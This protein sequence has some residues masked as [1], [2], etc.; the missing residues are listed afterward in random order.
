[1]SI[2][3]W[4]L[5]ELSNLVDWG[6]VSPLTWV[7]W[8]GLVVIQDVTTM[9][10]VYMKE[11]FNNTPA[12]SSLSTEER[13]RFPFQQGILFRRQGHAVRC[14]MSKVSR[15]SIMTLGRWDCSSGEHHGSATSL[16]QDGY[17]SSTHPLLQSSFQSHWYAGNLPSYFRKVSSIDRH[18]KT[19]DKGKLLVS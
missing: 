2:V 15:T 16:I 9:K 18:H 17:G 14:Y 6:G 10:N 8:F 5:T 12:K 1:M 7:N 11:S 4:Q 19:K 3:P 13:P